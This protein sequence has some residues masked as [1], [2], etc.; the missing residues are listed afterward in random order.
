MRI[1]FAKCH[2]AR[3]KL[4][5]AAALLASFGGIVFGQYVGPAV[6]LAGNSYSAPQLDE[7]VAVRDAKILPGDAIGI[8]ILGSPELTIPSLRVTPTGDVAL[9][10]L[11]S[12]HVADQTSSSI[13]VA[14]A[15]K[16]KEAG[17]LVDPQITVA[18][19][20]SPSRVITVV[21]EVKQ[22]QMVPAFSNFRLLDV[23]AACG[24]FTPSA[25][26]TLTV[27]KRGS[28][29]AVTVRLSVDPRMSDETNISL[30]PGD[31]V[32]VPK[33]GRIFIVGQVKAEQAIALEGNDPITVMRA[34][35]L[36][37]GLKYGAALSGARIVRNADPKAR[38][39][40]A[41]D[42][43]KIM[44]GQRPDPLLLAN[45]ILYIPT[46]AVKAGLANGGAAVAATSIYGLGSLVK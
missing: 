46:N 27:Q 3:A 36:A 32:I 18:I 23:I 30:A 14:L 26:H 28:N 8:A 39:E 20:E 42:L 11:G 21:G 10:Y 43:K 2:S 38:T 45:D 17:L 1:P 9:P 40:V 33:V 19:L 37:G 41:L 15:T 22:P 31:A 34:I 6:G 5:L 25:S 35:A 4:V 7:A 44:N 12:V 13:S 16:L 29:E 24:G